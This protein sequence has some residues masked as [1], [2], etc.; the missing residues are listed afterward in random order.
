MKPIGVFGGTFDPIHYGHIKPVLDIREFTGIPEIRYIPN[1]RPGHRSQP[2]TSALHRWNM[3]VLALDGYTELIADDREIQRAGTSYMVTTL[4]SLRSEF[5]MRPLC[6]ILGI[7]AF[8]QIHRWHWWAEV[9]KLAHIVVMSRP[10]TE[11]PYQLPDW[12]FQS[13]EVSPRKLHSKLSGFI[14]HVAVDRVDVSATELRNRISRGDDCSG[15][16]PDSVYAYIKQHN[17]YNNLGGT[18]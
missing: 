13:L 2:Q 4:R 10:G 1:S 17:L 18:S 12:W 5:V 3:T 7:D 6:L 9:L 16:L 14:L 15:V 8:L 11:F